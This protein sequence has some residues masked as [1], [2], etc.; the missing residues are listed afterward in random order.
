MFHLQPNDTAVLFQTS[1]FKD[2]ALLMLY[3][4]AVSLLS[5]TEMQFSSWKACRIS[6]KP[7]RLLQYVCLI[8]RVSLLQLLRSHSAKHLPEMRIGIELYC[9]CVC[10]C[11][12]LCIRA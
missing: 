4:D 12:C 5:D 7:V 3:L 10:V 6:V 9:V 1:S 2:L 8:F 11:V